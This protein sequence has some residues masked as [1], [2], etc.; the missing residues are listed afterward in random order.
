MSKIAEEK[1]SD[2]RCMT[3]GM[4][5]TSKRGYDCSVDLDRRRIMNKFHRGLQVAV[6]VPIILC[7]QVS[8]KL[9]QEPPF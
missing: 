8:V 4:L 3:I 1:L 7:T 6:E 2:G 5:L 9:L